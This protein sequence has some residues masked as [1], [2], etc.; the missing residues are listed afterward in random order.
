MKRNFILF[1]FVVLSAIPGIMLGSCSEEGFV[2]TEVTIDN[3][4][5]TIEEI[6]EVEPEEIQVI[7]LIQEHAV[8]I[9]DGRDEVNISC[10]SNAGIIHFECGGFHVEFASDY[11]REYTN[12]DELIIQ[13]EEADFPQRTEVYTYNGVEFRIDIQDGRPTEEDRRQF[14]SYYKSDPN[15][16]TLEYN[17]DGEKMAELLE[18]AE[19]KLLA[20]WRERNPDGYIRFIQNQQDDR[21]M[22]GRRYKVIDYGCAGAGLCGSIKCFFGGPANSLC[23]FCATV[24]AMCAMM[25]ILGWF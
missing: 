25:E 8:L 10:D 9:T 24:S 4:E 2:S 22:L 18:K 1:A 5:E 12:H 17:P 3:P 7:E 11:I 19:P 6:E 15:Q 16:N 13:F 23:L 20:I 21:P 14:L